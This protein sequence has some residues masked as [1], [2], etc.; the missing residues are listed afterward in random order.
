MGAS[1]IFANFSRCDESSQQEEFRPNLFLLAREYFL[2][3]NE[4]EVNYHTLTK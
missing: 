3:I 2:R 4:K 1:P